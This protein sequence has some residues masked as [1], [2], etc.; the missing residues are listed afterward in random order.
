MSDELK[1]YFGFLFV[2]TLTGLWAAIVIP[3]IIF[4]ADHLCHFLGI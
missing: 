3:G 4:I 2:M 1:V